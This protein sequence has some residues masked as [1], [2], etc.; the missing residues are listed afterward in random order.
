VHYNQFTRLWNAKFDNVV[1][2]RKVR[3]GVCVICANLKGMIKVIRTND[4]DKD[5]CRKDLKEHRDSQAL[6]R[7]K[8]MRHRDKALQSSDG[9]VFLIID[10]MD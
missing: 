1:I 2:L 7:M 8:S 9:H 10:G 5:N 4:I 3:M 6:E